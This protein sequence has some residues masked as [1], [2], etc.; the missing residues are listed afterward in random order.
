MKKPI[1]LE[2]LLLIYTFAILVGYGKWR[3]WLRGA[4]WTT[5]EKRLALG[6]VFG[7]F[8]GLAALDAF[9]NHRQDFHSSDGF[10]EDLG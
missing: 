9:Y 3:Y 5:K 4:G 10:Q 1:P 6:A 7:V 8:L 2:V